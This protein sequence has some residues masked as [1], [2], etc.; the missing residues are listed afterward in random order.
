MQRTFVAVQTT[1]YVELYAIGASGVY[2]EY[3]NVSVRVAEADRSTNFKG[4]QVFGSVVKTPVAT[5]ADL[6][7][8]S[9]FST[10]NYLVQ[11]YNNNLDFGTGDFSICLWFLASSA[12]AGERQ[13]LVDRVNSFYITR[14]YTG[15]CYLG[16][17][18]GSYLYTTN[19]YTTGT[20]MFVA[21]RKSGVLYFYVNGV[22]DPVGGVT[23]TNNATS[24]T[25]STYIGV[26]NG[27]S[28][29]LWHCRDKLSLLRISA[30]APS[31]AQILKM[32]NDEKHLFQESAKATLYG[33]SDNVTALAYDADTQL[34]HVGTSSGRSVF[35][36]LRRVDNTA[37]AV[38]TS[39]SASNGLVAE[40]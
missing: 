39:I 9:N 32:Y 15:R 26:D 30:T 13:S 35:N 27:L 2:A 14:E 4:L 36:G 29:S 21:V 24:G 1:T 20:M 8:Y 19:S 34:L 28:A 18:A 11:P 38:A 40:Q 6:V 7:S 12:N 25:P 33:A 3:D 23:N 17:G 37:T 22:L 16:V 31:D 5:N 10:S